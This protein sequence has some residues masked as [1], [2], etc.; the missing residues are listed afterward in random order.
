MFVGFNVAFF[1]MHISGCW[2][3]R[4]A[5]TPIPAELGWGSTEPDLDDRRL[6]RGGWRAG[7]PGDLAEKFAPTS[8]ER[9]GN[10]WGAGTLEWLRNDAYGPRSIPLVSSRDPLWDQ[11]NLAEDVEKGRYFLP[12][13]PTGQRETIVTSPI[14]AEPQ[15]V[16]RLPGQAG[17]RSSRRFSPRPSSCC[18]R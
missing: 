12:G 5:S 16:M 11:P 18:S 8:R 3:C 1:P 10:V 4:A 9:R 7:V 15:Y 14:E 2:G 13:A 6:Y 17:R